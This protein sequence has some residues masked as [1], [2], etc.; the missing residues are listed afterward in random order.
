MRIFA[1]TRSTS[2]EHS[3]V[4]KFCFCFS[5]LQ[6]NIIEWQSRFFCFSPLQTNILEWEWYVFVLIDFKPRL[7]N[8]KVVLLCYSTLNQHFRSAKI[9]FFCY[10]LLQTNVAEL[11]SL[12]F[13]LVHFKPTLQQE[14]V[15][16][17][18][19]STS[20]QHCRKRKLYF[21]FTL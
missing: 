2:N 6:T 17:L 12:V 8:R 15:V 4:G 16:S 11:E 10:N 18:F 13:N 19:Q 1:L 9:V 14:K 5:P 20:N 21:C 3:R 7:Y